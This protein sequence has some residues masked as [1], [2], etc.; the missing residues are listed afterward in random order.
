MSHAFEVIKL[1]GDSFLVKGTD[2]FGNEGNAKLHSPSWAAVLR[3]RRQEQAQEAFDAGVREF[4]QPLLNL[5]QEQEKEDLTTVTIFEDSP[6]VRG[7]SIKLDD[8]GV[9][10]NLLDQ[11]RGELLVWIDDHTLGA[12]EE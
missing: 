12:V 2:T 3:A 7:M 11:E 9:V 10:L 5:A 6:G 1:F 8:D 4:F